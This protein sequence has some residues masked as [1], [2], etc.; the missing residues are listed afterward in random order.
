M[1]PVTVP[2]RIAQPS[3]FFL[4]APAMIPNIPRMTGRSR[5]Y[6]GDGRFEPGDM[7]RAIVG[8]VVLMVSA[9]TVNAGLA[10]DGGR[11]VQFAPGGRPVQ[12]KLTVPGSCEPTRSVKKAALPAV[13]VAVGLGVERESAGVRLTMTA[14]L[15]FAVLTSP[16]PETVAVWV[17]LVAVEE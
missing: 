10:T 17:T 1:M 7:R 13:I 4:R 3:V 6:H 9:S 5:A 16:P 15:S 8:P 14:M 12:L 11:N 2:T